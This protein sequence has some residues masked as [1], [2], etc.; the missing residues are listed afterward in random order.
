MI[1]KTLSVPVT[2]VLFGLMSVFSFMLSHSHVKC[3]GTYWSE[4]VIIW[5][6]VAMT[7]GS[8]QSTVLLRLIQDVHTL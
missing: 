6:A 5:M 2:V 4:P 3:V 1:G 7:M 8:G